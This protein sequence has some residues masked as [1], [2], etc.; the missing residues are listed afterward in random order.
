[1]CLGTDCPSHW[2]IG[3]VVQ[4]RGGCGLGG[5]DPKSLHTHSGLL[6]WSR[7]LGSWWFLSSFSLE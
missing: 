6:L 4:G 5:V 2:G 3:V 7:E 1:M